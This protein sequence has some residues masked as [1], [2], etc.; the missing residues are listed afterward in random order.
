MRGRVQSIPILPLLG[1]KIVMI[2][3]FIF[4]IGQCVD[5]YVKSPMHQSRQGHAIVVCR[6]PLPVRSKDLKMRLNGSG[7]TKRNLTMVEIARAG[8]QAKKEKMMVGGAVKL[9]K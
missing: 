9:R 2:L 1:M 8:E 3:P 7:S 6:S 4:L 5:D